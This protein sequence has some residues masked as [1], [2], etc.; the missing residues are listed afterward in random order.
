M[1]DRDLPVGALAVPLINPQPPQKKYRKKNK[2]QYTKKGGKTNQKNG[3]G[4]EGNKKQL[5]FF[6]SFKGPGRAQTAR[7]VSLFGHLP[8]SWGSGCAHMRGLVHVTRHIKG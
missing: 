1:A 4:K 6:L 8:D 5:S 2:K 7:T 3:G